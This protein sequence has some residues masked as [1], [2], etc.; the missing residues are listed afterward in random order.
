MKFKKLCLSLC[1]LFFLSTLV[2]AGIASPQQ[3]LGY[4]VGDDF[5]LART[6]RFLFNSL[7][8]P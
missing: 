2:K 5:K 6:F 7:I 4:R 1:L 8:Y 3:F